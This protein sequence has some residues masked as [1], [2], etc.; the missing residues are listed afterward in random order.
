MVT[1]EEVA[2]RAGVSV[3]TVSNVLNN[4]PFVS[5]ETRRKV[6]Q[7]ILELNYSPNAIA[8]SLRR[9]RT[10]SLALIVLDVSNPFYPEVIQGV[11]HTAREYGYHVILFDLA[12]SVRRERRFIQRL[13]ELRLDGVL[14]TAGPQWD[15]VLLRQLDL[16]I[17]LLD[18]DIHESS[19]PTVGIDNAAAV[20]QGIRYLVQMGHR[21]IGYLSE[22]LEIPS[23]RRRLE[24][25]RQALEE[26]GIPFSNE[27][28]FISKELRTD[29]LESGYLL[30]QRVLQELR[31]L[32]TAFFATSDS[33]AIGAM[34]ALKEHGL[35]IP[36]DISILGFDD[37]VMTRF[38]D[39]PLTTIAQPKVEM[40]HQAV[41][42]LIERIERPERPPVK[43]M[44][45][46]ALIE[47][48][49]VAPPRDP[50]QEE[51]PASV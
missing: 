30:M 29:K 48:K 41:R 3:G 33:I 43:V 20:A 17:V 50:V 16:P 19:L 39:P 10:R 9:G 21:R 14:L 22:P 44:L 1:I 24:G 7:A 25:Y 46:T 40:G 5:P 2:R 42:L 4:K 47:R 35:R 11:E 32:P 45:E 6:E 15:E 49:S 28:I 27:I 31:E 38:V 37:I 26:A 12:Y 8:R 51:A 18:R 13:R 23:V 34:Q 36:E